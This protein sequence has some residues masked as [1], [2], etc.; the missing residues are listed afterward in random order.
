MGSM[1]GS[2]G[3]CE[4]DMPRACRRGTRV[5][6]GAASLFRQQSSMQG[7][8]QAVLVFAGVA[9]RPGATLTYIQGVPI[10]SQ[11]S[12]DAVKRRAQLRQ[13]VGLP[14]ALIVAA[15]LQQRVK[16]LG[17]WAAKSCIASI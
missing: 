14:V 6:L 16:G 8:A 17:L 12:L 3:A 5:S 11:H 10:T 7:A 13:Q 4:P 15:G 9:P 1:L 2:G